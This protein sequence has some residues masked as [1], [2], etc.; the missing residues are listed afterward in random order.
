MGE[1]PEDRW[2]NLEVWQLADQ[3]AL[4]VYRHSRVFPSEERYGLTSQLRRSA[5][6]VPTNIV[7]GYSR[8]GDRE[9]GHFLS[10]A[11]GSLAETKYLLHFASQLEYLAEPARETLFDGYE[12]LGRQLWRF[13]EKVVK[14]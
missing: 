13:Y 11:L 14:E 12:R 10:V 8:R 7:E 3:M 1:H 9:L 4:E 6:S 2:R 5:L